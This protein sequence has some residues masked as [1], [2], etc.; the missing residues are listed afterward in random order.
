[1]TPEAFI[2]KWDEVTT[3]ERAASHTHFLDLCELLEVYKPL[4]VVRK[5]DFYAFERRVIL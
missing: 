4:D 3:T 2:D 1:M 5:G